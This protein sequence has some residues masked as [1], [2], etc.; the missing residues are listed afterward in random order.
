[1]CGGCRHEKLLLYELRQ[2]TDLFTLVNWRSDAQ[3]Q[4]KTL[5]IVLTM[6]AMGKLLWM[7]EILHHLGWL[8]PYKS[9]DNP[10]INWCRI[11]S[12]HSIRYQLGGF[13]QPAGYSWGPAPLH[14][15]LTDTFLQSSAW[16]PVT[17]RKPAKNHRV[18]AP[19]HQHIDSIDFTLNF[20]GPVVLHVQP[21]ISP[22]FGDNCFGVHKFPPWRTVFH[23]RFQH[24]RFRS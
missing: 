9:W 11:S 23:R 24:P 1:M 15:S 14:V 6:A 5:K 7:E 17:S 21:V 20:S 10:L 18:L 4:V 3:T 8:K 13:Q 22:V 16:K 12:I 2:V 19:F